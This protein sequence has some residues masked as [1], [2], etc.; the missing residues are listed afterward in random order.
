MVW[1]CFSGNGTGCL[2]IIKGRRNVP[3]YRDI[4]SEYLI[5][6]V[7]MLQ[8]GQNFVFQ[9]DND[10]KHTAKATSRIW[11]LSVQKNGQIFHLPCA[12]T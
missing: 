1:G 3:M 5:R 4:L 6:S 9:Q 2:Q 12:K 8:C 11:K 10:P 7:E